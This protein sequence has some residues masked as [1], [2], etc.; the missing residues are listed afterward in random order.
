M[1]GYLCEYTMCNARKMHYNNLS[2]AL[3]T[4]KSDYGRAII[5]I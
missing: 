5:N 4:D 1:Q 2:T 3:V